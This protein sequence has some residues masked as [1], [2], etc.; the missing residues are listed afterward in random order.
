M[1]TSD[2]QVEKIM[3]QHPEVVSYFIQKGVSPI[4]CAGAFPATLGMLLTIK[5]V[6]DVDGFI[7]GLND[8]IGSE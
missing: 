2:T 6:E 7:K 3:E 8:F 4:S 5:K 1:I